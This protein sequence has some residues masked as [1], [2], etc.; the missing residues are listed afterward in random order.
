[1]IY[2]EMDQ[3]WRHCIKPCLL[4]SGYSWLHTETHIDMYIYIGVNTYMYISLFCQLKGPRSN[5]ITVT[6]NRLS[7][8]I[9]VSNTI[10]LKETRPGNL[11]RKCTR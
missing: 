1:M 11:G 9:L 4:L 2:V 8:Q 6:S 5:N 7:V 10:L 3:S